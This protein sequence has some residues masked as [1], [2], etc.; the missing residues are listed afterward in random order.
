MNLTVQSDYA[1]RTLMLLAARDPKGSTIQEISEHY[2]ISRGHLMV[3]VHR[4]GNL[5]FLENTRGRGGGIRLARPASEIRLDEIVRATEPGFQ[6]VE[7]FAPHSSQCL[8][9]GSCRLHGILEEALEAWLAVLRKY[10]LSDLV[11]G[12]P[13]LVHLLNSPGSTTGRGAPRRRHAMRS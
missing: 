13:A 9:T 2:G 8:I 3:L 11:R 4:L 6:M 5:G 7:C 10:S 12:N 1:F